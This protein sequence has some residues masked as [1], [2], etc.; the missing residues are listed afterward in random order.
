M[1]AVVARL[2]AGA[3]MKATAAVNRKRRSPSDAAVAWATVAE[4]AVLT[5]LDECMVV[6]TSVVTYNC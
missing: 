6:D 2:L 5:M 4:A 1:V 3:A